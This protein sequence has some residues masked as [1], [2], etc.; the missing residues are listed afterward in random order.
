MH[1]KELKGGT[2]EDGRCDQSL[3]AGHFRVAFA[4]EEGACEG[5]CF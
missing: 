5:L 4:Y 1:L 3:Y 2:A